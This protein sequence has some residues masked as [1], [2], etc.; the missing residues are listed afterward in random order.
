MFENTV[1]TKTTLLV[2]SCGMWPAV[3]PGLSFP[4]ALPGGRALLST[5]QPRAELTALHILFAVPIRRAANNQPCPLGPPQPCGRQ[6]AV[7]AP[8]LG[9]HPGWMLFP[10]PLSGAVIASAGGTCSPES[11]GFGQGAF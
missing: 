1:K 11:G 10:A 3:Q 7:P 4:C 6:G 9:F 2:A 5:W 8:S